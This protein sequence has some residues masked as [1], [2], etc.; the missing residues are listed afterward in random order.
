MNDVL[1]NVILPLVLSVMMYTMGLTL[2]IDDFKRV[3]RKPKA[4]FLGAFNQMLVLP[5]SVFVIVSMAGLPPAFAA[6]FMILAAC[7]GGITSNVMCYYA[8]GDT[9]LSI[10]LTAVVSLVS[11]ITLP[12]IVGYSIGHFLGPE[13]VVDFPTVRIAIS[14]FFI[15]VVPVALGMATLH[16]LPRVAVRIAPWFDRATVVLFIVVVIGAIRRNWE[17]VVANMAE[18]G[19]ISLAICAAMLL[20]GFLTARLLRLDKP[21]ATAIS[22]ET[23]VQNAATA[24][25]VGGTLLGSEVLYLP[26]AIYGVCM[27]LPAGLLLLAARYM[28]NSKPSSAV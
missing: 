22:L 12:L 1:V 28:I 20:I 6:G 8:R 14:L 3:G 23:G 9:A 11:F 16:F 24:I 27:Y 18:L 13:K 15:N 19:G 4:F 10:S 21:Q 25:L 17:L 5:V 2:V 7:P 26:G